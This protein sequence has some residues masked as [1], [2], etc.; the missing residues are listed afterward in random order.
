MGT[1]QSDVLKR[2]LFVLTHLKTLCSTTSRFPSYLFPSII[3]NDIHIIGPLS[4]VSYAYEHSKT[5]LRAIGLFI[6]P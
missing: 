1:H 4:I 3:A 2:A 6:Q 5:E